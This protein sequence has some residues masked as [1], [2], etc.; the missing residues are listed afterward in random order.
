MPQ[1]DP[2]SDLAFTLHRESHADELHQAR[3]QPQVSP[4]EHEE[5]PEAESTPVSI[6]G[7]TNCLVESP[8]ASTQGSAAAPANQRRVRVH[9]YRQ[10]VDVDLLIQAILIIAEEVASPSDVDGTTTD[11]PNPATGARNVGVRK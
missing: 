8:L 11:R 4:T 5:L 9:S 2:V 3:G 7:A 6:E 10:E 1:H